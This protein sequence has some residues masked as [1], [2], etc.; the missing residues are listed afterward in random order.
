MKEIMRHSVQPRY[1]IFIKGYGFRSNA[2]NI[3]ENIGKNIMK[4]LS[5]K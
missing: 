3:S 5:D 2:E 4:N 1:Q